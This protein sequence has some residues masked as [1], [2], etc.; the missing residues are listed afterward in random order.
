[1]TVATSTDTRRAAIAFGMF[2]VWALGA[3]QSCTFGLWLAIGSTAVF[4]GVVASFLEGRACSSSKHLG[5]FGLI[6]QSHFQRLWRLCRPFQILFASSCQSLALDAISTH[7]DLSL[8]PRVHV[9]RRDVA[10]CL[11]VTAVVV[12]LVD[13]IHP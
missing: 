12:V 5:L 6:S 3:W 9:S 1:M 4:L 7:V 11:V 10:Q 2:L 8:A 13:S